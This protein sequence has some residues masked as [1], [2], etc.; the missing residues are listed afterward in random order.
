MYTQHGLS[1]HYCNSFDD[2]TLFFGNCFDCGYILCAAHNIWFSLSIE[3]YD[4]VE[5]ERMVS[6]AHHAVDDTA[7]EGVTEPDVHDLLTFSRITCG[8]CPFGSVWFWRNMWAWV[9]ISKEISHHP[10]WWPLYLSVENI[11]LEFFVPMSQFLSSIIFYFCPRCYH[12]IA[13]SIPRNWVL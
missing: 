13:L 2:P 6:A 8:E 4:T 5:I 9:A 3:W 7:F 10:Q 12:E 11:V 1:N